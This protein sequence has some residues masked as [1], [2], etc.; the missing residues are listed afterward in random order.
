MPEQFVVPHFTSQ[1]TNRYNLLERR[2]QHFDQQT[3]SYGEASLLHG[4]QYHL[5]LQ[6]RGSHKPSAK[7]HQLNA[8]LLDQR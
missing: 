6:G 4:Q 3:V 7:P 1:E 2:S 5:D 8:G